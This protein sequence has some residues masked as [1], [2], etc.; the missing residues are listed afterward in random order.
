MAQRVNLG[1]TGLP[2]RKKTFVAKTA[3]AIF[4]L[5]QAA[6]LQDTDE[7]FLIL[8]TIAHDDISPSIRVVNNNEEITSNGNLFTAF[9]FEIELPDSKENSAPRA[10]LS[11]DNV[12]R[13]IAEAIRTITTVATITIEIIRAADPDTIEITW[14]PF[15][16]RNV[17]WDMFRVSGDLV[18]EEIELE[19]F[20]VGQF[21]PGNFSALF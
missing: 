13:E 1:T 21:T 16:L 11:I 9:P 5:K 17:K 3:S 20:P 6:F 19:P 2:V 12:S 15:N 14:A 4:S 8:L 10:R 7:V 18:A